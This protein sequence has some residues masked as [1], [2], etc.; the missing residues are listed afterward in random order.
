MGK[1]RV[2]L[3]APLHLGLVS[4]IGSCPMSVFWHYLIT[5][6]H[7]HQFEASKSGP[8]I[9]DSSF[10]YPSSFSLFSCRVL[11][12]YFF[13]H[14]QSPCPMAEGFCHKI[15]CWHQCDQ[16]GQFLKVLGNKCTYKSSPKRL[17]TFGLFWK[18]LI[19]VITAVEIT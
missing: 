7:G 3:G 9:V 6:L 12:I 8:P 17:L 10:I 14:C 13:S 4:K 16:I 15:Y 5:S 18:R 11:L 19:N 1:G 2:D